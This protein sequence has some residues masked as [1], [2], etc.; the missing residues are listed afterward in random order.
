MTITFG[1]G[2]V[3]KAMGQAVFETS[4][5]DI[6]T[7]TPVRYVP[8]ASANFFSVMGVTRKDYEVWVNAHRGFVLEPGSHEPVLTARESG[9][10]YYL[11]AKLMEPPRTMVDRH[12]P[13]FV[14]QHGICCRCT[15][16]L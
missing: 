15:A 7:I 16:W 4:S 9:G 1:N 14:H 5:G 3:G 2:H 11:I 6:I 12:M 10:V 8:E 13:V